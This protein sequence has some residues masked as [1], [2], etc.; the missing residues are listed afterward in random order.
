MLNR[1]RIH[2]PPAQT[3][4]V[5]GVGLWA[6]SVLSYAL[7]G[8][9]VARPAIRRVDGGIFS[10]ITGLSS[11]YKALLRSQKRLVFGDLT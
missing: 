6:S 2:N 1:A 7:E 9:M 5:P 3:T 8:G 4:G 10:H 11:V